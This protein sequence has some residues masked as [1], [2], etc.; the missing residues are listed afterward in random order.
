[1]E[2]IMED[3]KKSA[4]LLAEKGDVDSIRNSLFAAYNRGRGSSIVERLQVLKPSPGDVII[5]YAHSDTEVSPDDMLWLQEQI[6]RY[7]KNVTCITIPEGVTIRRMNE[8]GM[9]QA[10]WIK[11]KLETAS[12]VSS[13]ITQ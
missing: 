3:I 2:D 4:E 1:M 9:R 5:F 8:D 10:G 7:N 12:S 11:S 6:D 13:I